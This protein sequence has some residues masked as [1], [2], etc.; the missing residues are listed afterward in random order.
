VSIEEVGVRDAIHAE[1]V[2]TSTPIDFEELERLSVLEERDGWYLILNPDGPGART[3]AGPDRPAGPHRR[4][5]CDELD[6]SEDD[7]G[8]GAAREDGLTRPRFRCVTHP[9]VN[10]V[11]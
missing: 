3:S 8:C 6:V 2:A 10:N 4:A 7:E 1:L 9:Q 11:K 5:R